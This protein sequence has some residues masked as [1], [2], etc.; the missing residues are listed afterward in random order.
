MPTP[1]NSYSYSIR[2][3]KWAQ[4]SYT[5]SFDDLSVRNDVQFEAYVHLQMKPKNQIN[6]QTPFGLKMTQ[7]KSRGEVFL[8]YAWTD[9]IEGICGNYN[10]DKT[11]DYKCGDGTVHPFNQRQSAL[12]T[13]DCWR[14]DGTIGPDPNEINDDECDAAD[15]CYTLFEDSVFNNCL[16]KIDPAPFIDACRVDYCATP[17]DETLEEIYEMFIGQCADILPTDSAVCTWREVVDINTCPAGTEWHGCKPQCDALEGCQ[18]PGNCDN[19]ILIA[20][21]FCP[22]GKVF[23]K[24]GDCVTPDEC[25]THWT[26]WGDCSVTCGGGVREREGYQLAVLTTESRVCNTEVCPFNPLVPH[27]ESDCSCPDNTWYCL[28]GCSRGKACQRVGLDSTIMKC[29]PKKLGICTAYGDPHI[30]TFDGLR[31][32][33]YGVGNYTLAQFNED[34]LI[35]VQDDLKWELVM[36]TQ[37]RRLMKGLTLYVTG[38]SYNYQV[39]CS[40]NLNPSEFSVDY[41]YNFQ[42]KPEMTDAEFEDYIQLKERGFTWSFTLPFGMSVNQ[43]VYNGEVFVPLAFSTNVEGICGDYNFDKRNDFKCEDGTVHWGRGAMQATA[44]CWKWTADPEVVFDPEPDA[45]IINENTCPEGE[46]CNTLFDNAVFANCVAAVDPTPFIN[47]CKVDYCQTPETETLEAIY[48]AFIDRCA[49]ILPEDD[50]VCTWREVVGINSC[51]VGTIFHG[52]KPECDALFSCRV[53][54]NCDNNRLIEGCFCPDG[55]AF[56]SN[57]ECVAPDQCEVDNW[58][59]WGECSKSCG[60]GTKTRTGLIRVDDRYYPARKTET[61]TCNTN[62]CPFDPNADPECACDNNEWMCQ[63]GCSRGKTC[64]RINL[65]TTEMKCLKAQIGKCWCYGDPHI[66]TFDGLKNDVYGI[67]NYTYAQFNESNSAPEDLTWEII[68]ETEPIAHVSRL[69]AYTLSVITNSQGSA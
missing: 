21:C 7:R 61:S 33:I 36:E 29:L 20:G 31:H 28:G 8:P 3:D 16:A 22:T 41:N 32:D 65:E 19:V 37:G 14:W 39:S 17:T 45:D 62:V 69:R 44:E 35:V 34:G 57:N 40:Y 11:D 13:A 43:K 42:D 60:G 68:M 2:M 59:E 15:V 50:A 12:A 55:T 25:P 51:P 30:T 6:I 1:A 67:A 46:I 49:N 38:N 24:D 63:G 9:K 56:N 47:T 5:Y 52:C 54:T 48:A 10:F 18:G 27:P 58:S 53:V 23:N 26:E 66:I 64:Q 4:V